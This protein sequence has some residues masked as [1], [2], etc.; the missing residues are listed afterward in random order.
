MLG[1][2]SYG[3]LAF[4]ASSGVVFAGVARIGLD[5]AFARAVT[6]ADL[7]ASRE[8]LFAL[9]RGAVAL[10]L[11]GGVLAA[12]ATAGIVFA[13]PHHLQPLAG[14]VVGGCVAIYVVGTNVAAVTGALARGL[15]R[16]PLMEL[17]GLT[18]ALA[19]TSG[20][21][22]IWIVGLGTLGWAAAVYGVAG[23]AA[24]LTCLA[25]SS[26]LLRAPL[27]ALRPATADA[28]RLA[29][30][31]IPYAAVGASAVVVSRL[32]VLVLGV[33]H[34]SAAVAEY[35]PL[36]K[37]VEQG[38]LWAPFLFMAP[39]LPAATRL[40]AAGDQRAF[41]HL[42][43]MTSKL[44]V[45][46]AAPVAIVLAVDPVRSLH[47]V[48]GSSYNPRP[49]L[50]WVLLAGF[51]IN[52]A[53]GLN[54]SAL[55]ALGSRREL[56]RLGALQLMTMT[57]LAVCL[58][59]PFGAVGAAVATSATYAIVNI[60][61]SLALRRVAG[62]AVVA[63]PM[64]ITIATAMLPLAASALARGSAPESSFVGELGMVALLWL[65]WLAVL[66]RL[67]AISLSEIAGFD[68][69]KRRLA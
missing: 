64:A 20:L 59:P 68:P 40:H 58:V 33:T 13:A 52:L 54:L 36:L 22:G 38:M 50:I 16:M 41:G 31:A 35:E 29:R 61:A 5:A 2:S 9:V 60:A 37:L 66:R 25:L 65:C 14:L 43:A 21:A 1:P 23:A 53:C 49:E 26:G 34:R 27:R 28:R 32:D 45:V 18:L 3:V 63:R 12:A 39:F 8:E 51:A 7:A 62:L 44:V 48:Y 30:V 19:R 11:A 67:G 55:A 15:G 56:M 17:P 4:S 42:Y 24:A 46:A 10:V 57:V 47:V 6:R 69:R